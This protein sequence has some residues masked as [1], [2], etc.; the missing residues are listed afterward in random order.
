MD[1]TDR[2]IVSILRAQGRVPWAELG[3]QVGLS[4]PAVQERVRRLEES[5][6][7]T[8]YHAAVDPAALGLGVS[9]VVGVYCSDGAETDDVARRLRDVPEIEDCWYVA[10]DEEFLVTVR[11]TDVAALESVVGKIRRLRG[12]SRTRTT[13]VLSTRWENRPVPW[14]PGVTD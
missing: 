11:A 13:V 9:A 3:R 6:V 5:R 8:G 14:D 12:V 10:G 1:P 4:G 2:Q 7:V